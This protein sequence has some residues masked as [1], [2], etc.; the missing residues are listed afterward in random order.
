LRHIITAVI[1]VLTLATPLVWYASHQVAMCTAFTAG[2]N[3]YTF[4]AND[5]GLGFVHTQDSHLKGQTGF[6]R[7]DQAEWDSVATMTEGEYDR[8][9]GFRRLQIADMATFW[10]APFWF[11]QLLMLALTARAA[12]WQLRMR[13]ERRAAAGL[14]EACGYDLRATPDRCPE[15]GREPAG[16]VAPPATSPAEAS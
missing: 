6:W 3:R 8:F 16:R 5:G 4:V 14:C 1:A 9:L 13:R 10:V 2:D 11:V 7:E 15:C 12:L